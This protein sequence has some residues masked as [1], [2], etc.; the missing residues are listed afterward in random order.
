MTGQ[1]IPGPIVKSEAILAVADVAATIKFYREKLG[2]TKDW[3]WDDPPT[4][5]GVQWGDVDVSFHLAP[6]LAK[7]VEGHQHYFFVKGVDDMQARH[8]QNGVPIISP[9]ERKQWG[10]REYTVRDP[11]GYH[12]RFGER[13]GPIEQSRE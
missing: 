6:E 2:F 5:G 1:R 10:M 4:H 11:N 9:I 8:Q 7:H 12:L 13:C 3:V